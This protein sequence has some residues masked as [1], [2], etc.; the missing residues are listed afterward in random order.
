MRCNACVL[1]SLHL[2]PEPEIGGLYNVSVLPDYDP[3]IFALN[4]NILAQQDLRGKDCK[5]IGPWDMAAALCPGTLVAVEA[6]L[7]VYS[8]CKKID[9]AMV[10]LLPLHLRLRLTTI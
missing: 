9:P 6:N 1:T 7:I 8:F 3:K 10:R 5:L 2:G 4:Q